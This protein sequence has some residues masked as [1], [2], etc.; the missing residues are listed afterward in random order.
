MKELYTKENSE[1]LEKNQSWHSEDS[2]WKAEKI[3]KI[4]KNNNIAPKSVVE[5]G[6]GVGEILHNLN[7]KI[8][9][10]FVSFEG[11]DIAKDAINMAAKIQSR[12]IKFFKKD[13][14]TIEKDNYDLLLMIDV[15]EHVPDY[16]GFIN[17]CK[18]KA[19][20]KVY[21]IPLDISIYRLLKKGLIKSRN[22]VG[23]LHYFNKDTALATIKD[24]GQEVIDFFYTDGAI[25]LQK[26]STVK[27][28]IANIS[29]K[30]I[31]PLKPDL[32]VKVFGG[33]SLLVLAR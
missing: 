4:L 1:Y 10:P 24:T 6:C 9:D 32:T 25:A 13:F 33:Y 14:T 30:L 15:F 22:A 23:H 26:H 17:K 2:P 8:G 7:E 29:R 16:L 12:N 20:Y 31:F 18:N 3:F 28:K 27:S 11:Y 5:V 21:H 19:K